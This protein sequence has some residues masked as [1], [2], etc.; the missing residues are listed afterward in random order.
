MEVQKKDP[1]T[2]FQSELYNSVSSLA[3]PIYVPEKFYPH[4]SL[5]Y[6]TPSDEVVNQLKPLVAS[7][8]LEDA[9][10]EYDR[11]ELWSCK[12][13][14]E[15][16][17]PLVSIPLG[18]DLHFRSALFI[19][20][21]WVAP[22]SKNYFAVVNP[23]TKETIH[24]FPG[25]NASDINS[26]VA[27]AK[28]AFKTWGATTGAQRAV[29]LNAIADGLEAHA[30]DFIRLEVLDNGKPYKE[31]RNDVGD[32]AAC[33]RYYAKQAIEL[34]SKQDSV[35]KLGDADYS[36]Q[37]RYEPVGVAGMII[38]WNY[39]LLMAAWKV[40]PC[41]AAGCTGVLKPSE[42]TP[43][44]ALELASLFKSV[45]LPEGVMN[46][47]TGFG[48]DAGEPLTSHPDVEKIAFTGSVATGS[49][50]ASAA[51]GSIKKV[52]LELG[53]KS[54]F[55]IFEDANLEQAV[56]WTMMGIFFNQGQVCSATSRLLVQESIYDSLIKRLLEEV[57]KLKIGPGIDPEN[58][59]G[60]I[61]SEGQY[62]RV[63]GFIN[64]GKEEGA[65]ILTGGP[66]TSREELKK[67]FF[68]EPTI[69]TDV[70]DNMSVWKEEIFGPVLCIRKFKT[71]EEAVEV[72]NNT[73]Y[74]LA[75][76]VMSRDPERC[77]RVVRALRAGIVWVN[78]SQPT[79]VE[80]PWGGMKKS[81][82]GR[83]L[84][85]WGL[86]NY[87]EVKQVTSYNVSDGLGYQWYLQK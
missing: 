7:E 16:W 42:L 59:L 2:S 15:E 48:P 20:N 54:P 26:A 3:G 41:L 35:I 22:S 72:A 46:V 39:P 5:Y 56:E 37:I 34:D 68:V 79:F 1:L 66:E 63:T 32:T 80:A 19:N 13:A 38:P 57:K 9:N 52:S 84:G 50:V 67:G 62:K 64:K 53:G 82:T 61:V 4:V 74:G 47:V 45:G 40:A 11:V 29:Y 81:G 27:A 87:L 78:C 18:S 36:C 21:Q 76:A 69:F 83:E 70:T 44:S 49:R 71:E 23:A 12:G 65:K 77:K 85:P 55:I 60:P 6:G 28:K 17:F 86:D 30:E 33:F 58:K 43:L 73:S 8:K 31:A 75:G 24:N 25:A 14:V 51:S 10:V